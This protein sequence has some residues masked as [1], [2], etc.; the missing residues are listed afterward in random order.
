MRPTVSGFRSQNS[1]DVGV[2]TEKTPTPPTDPEDKHHDPPASTHPRPRQYS[3]HRRP[4][5]AA[6][7]PDARRLPDPDDGLGGLRPA[8]RRPGR[9][10][11]RQPVDRARLAD[12]QPVQPERRDQLAELQHR[13]RRGGAVR[14]AERQFGG[15]EPGARPRPVQHLRQ[16]QRQRQGVRGQSQRR[17]VRARIAGQCRRPG[18]LDAQ[19][20][21]RQLHEG[22]LQLFRRRR[23]RGA[24]PRYDHRER[25]RLC[26]PAGRQRRQQRRHRR[27]PGFGGAGRRPGDHPRRGR[28]RPAQR[29]G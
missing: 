19:H 6:H 20:H 1:S 4:L 12:R 16:P 9:R 15:S 3:H 5:Q 26:R 17:A 29:H 24:E 13:E 23:R 25:R 22:R 7:A 14:A 2:R 11:R 28:Q 18:G 21:R 10:G 27:Q 8:D